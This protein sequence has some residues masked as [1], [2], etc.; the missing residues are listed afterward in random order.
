[1]ARRKTGRVQDFAMLY[2]LGYVS[3]ATSVM[4]R[5]DLVAILDEARRLN[6]AAAVTGLL[7]FHD[8]TFFQVLEGERKDVLETFERIAADPRHRDIRVLFREGVGE[9]LFADWSM[10]FQ[11]IDGNQVLEFPDSAD[12]PVDLRRMTGDI[13]KAK[14]L[15]LLMRRHGLD[16]DREI[17]TAG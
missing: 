16:P 9:R 2:Q 10:G 12:G 15:M 7:L 8:G 17:V 11:L 3:I 5:D 6:R 4:Q 14:R 13:G 1:M